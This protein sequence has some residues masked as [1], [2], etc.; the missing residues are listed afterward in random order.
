MI[1]EPYEYVTDYISLGITEP[2]GCQDMSHLYTLYTYVYTFVIRI[3]KHMN[4]YTLYYNVQYTMTI[5]YTIY[6]DYLDAELN[7][8]ADNMLLPKSSVQV[9]RTE[10]IIFADHTL[11]Q[12]VL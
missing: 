4:V 5:R 11:Y 7:M 12:Y 6:N 8:F 3:T 10:I 9:P 2:C 1:F